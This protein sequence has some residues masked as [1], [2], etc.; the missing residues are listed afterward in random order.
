M[1]KLSVSHTGRH[2]WCLTRSLR[3]A[4]LMLSEI[5]QNKIEYFLRNMF[6]FQFARVLR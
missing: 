5:K 2:V 4:F 3:N 1:D 6:C